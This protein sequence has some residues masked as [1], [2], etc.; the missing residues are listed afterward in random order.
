M[1]GQGDGLRAFL[2]LDSRNSVDSGLREAFNNSLFYVSN[3]IN[4]IQSVSI[5]LGLDYIDTFPKLRYSN[6]SKLSKVFGWIVS[7]MHRCRM[8]YFKVDSI[9]GNM[10]MPK[11]RVLN[12]FPARFSL[13][14]LLLVA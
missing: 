2:L 3:G 5:C 11:P 12:R 7:I 10:L 8:R 9:P 13:S 6:T 4:S 1:K 14:R